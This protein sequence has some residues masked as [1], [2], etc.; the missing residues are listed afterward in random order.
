[1][2]ERVRN[3]V[4]KVLGLGLSE[5]HADLAP[6]DVEGWDSNKHMMLLM[7]AEEEFGLEFSDDEM[8]SVGSVGDLTAIVQ[9]HAA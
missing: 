7:A 9:R 3:L 6:G 8:I 1:M 5:V 4:A 2:D